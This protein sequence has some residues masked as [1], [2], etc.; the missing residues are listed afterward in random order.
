MLKAKSHYSQDWHRSE[1]S[2]EG[3]R[4]LINAC[5]KAGLRMHNPKGEWNGYG[6]ENLPLVVEINSLG[7]MRKFNKLK[8]ECEEKRASGK[9]KKTLTPEQKKLAW[10]KR[11]AKLTGIDTAEALEIADE[12]LEAKQDRI[13]EL[14]E[15]QSK[16]GYSTKRDKVINKLRREN[17]LR[18]IRDRN[19]ADNILGAHARHTETAYENYLEYLHELED[20]KGLQRGYARDLARLLVEGK[21]SIV[22]V[23]DNI[24]CPE[25]LLNPH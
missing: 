21:I 7:D 9:A 3:D 1:S 8:K 10:A 24:H 25:I 18:Y 5:R 14:E 11:F 23:D 22:E 19:H 12:K 20:E 15:R 2:F 13:N 17:P 6:Y 4:M 16:D